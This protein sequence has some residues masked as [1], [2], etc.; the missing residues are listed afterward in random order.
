MVTLPSMQ[1]FACV[2]DSLNLIGHGIDI[3]AI[4]DIEALVEQAG[5]HFEMQY[6]TATERSVAE[7]GAKRI[8]YLAGRL[9]AKTAVLKAL[10]IDSNQNTFWLDIE[11]Q[12]LST[13]EPSV[14]LHGQCQEIAT[15]LGLTKLLLSISHVSSYAAASVIC[16]GVRE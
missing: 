8:Q 1:A 15:E 10:G 9:C 12:R 5:K 2:P 7:S 6:F 13:G 11:V 16:L 3:I 4:H 14:V